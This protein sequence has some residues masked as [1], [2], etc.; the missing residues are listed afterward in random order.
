MGNII[1]FEFKKNISSLLIWLMIPALIS[2]V[3]LS[4]YPSFSEAAFDVEKLLSSYPEEMLRVL[5]INVNSI[6][7]M[8]SYYPMVLGFLQ[9][10]AFAFSATLTL[11]IFC[12]EYKNKS[13]EFILSKPRS[14]AT[15]FNA[16]IISIVLLNGIFFILLSI[17]DFIIIKVLSDMSFINF[18]LQQLTIYIIMIVATLITSIFAIKFNKIRGYDGVGFIIAF[19]F[20]F[21]NILA[22]ILDESKLAYLSIYGIFDLN[23]IISEGYNFVTLAILFTFG[24]V[25]YVI[26]LTMYKKK[27]VL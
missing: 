8:E 15:F 16:K 5:N 19:S 26:S 1:K 21:I 25:L 23:A 17:I 13:I 7:K 12:K 24:V 14:R 3:Y 2:V 22:T 6:S 27:D 10:I 11:K 18:L 9:L 4:V 20:Y